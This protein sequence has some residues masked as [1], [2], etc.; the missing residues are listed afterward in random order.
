VA[1]RLR[2]ETGDFRTFSRLL[3]AGRVRPALEGVE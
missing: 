2:H 1:G 3:G